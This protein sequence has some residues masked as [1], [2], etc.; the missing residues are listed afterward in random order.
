M[1]GALA[2]Q[3]NERCESR[4]ILNDW[5]R[6]ARS[7]ARSRETDNDSFVVGMTVCWGSKRY[8]WD[9]GVSIPMEVH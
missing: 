5:A 3:K 7:T 2:V 6:K 8:C 1:F 9:R 4:E